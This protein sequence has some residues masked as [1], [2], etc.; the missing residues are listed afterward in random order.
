MIPCT[1]L[2]AQMYRRSENTG[3]N[4]FDLNGG[5]STST[6]ISGSGGKLMRFDDIWLVKK[7][8]IMPSRRCTMPWLRTI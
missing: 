7:A 4:R 6:G 2:L 5:D 3:I 1:V 8:V